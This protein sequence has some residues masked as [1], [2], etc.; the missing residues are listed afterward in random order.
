MM[1]KVQCLPALG[2]FWCALLLQWSPAGPEDFLRGGR[3]LKGDLLWQLGPH[4]DL[5]P[6]LR[7][8]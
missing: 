7:C 2:L 4:G 6:T 1:G 3:Q 8:L 5:A